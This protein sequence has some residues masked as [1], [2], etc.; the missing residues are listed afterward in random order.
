MTLS[1]VGPATIG[2]VAVQHLSS[3]VATAKGIPQQLSATDFYLD[4]NSL[5]P[6][7]INFNV[8]SDTNIGTSFPVTVTLSNYQ[9]VNGVQIPFH[10]RKMVQGT[11]VLDVLVSSAA[12]NSGISD[13]E[14]NLQ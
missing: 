5:L 2:S 7:Q 12:L 11:V 9:P 10:I 13:S 6:V 3:V 14:F 8:Y 4:A 1:Y